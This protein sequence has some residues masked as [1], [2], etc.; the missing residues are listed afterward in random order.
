MK[1]VELKNINKYYGNDLILEDISFSIYSG[2]VVGFLGPNGAGKSTTMRILCG[3]L[4]PDSGEYLFQKEDVLLNPDMIKNKIGYLPEDPP[5][6]G[7]LRVKENLN[8]FYDL[9]ESSGNKRKD[10]N[11][12][13]DVCGL[14][15][16]LNKLT[17]TLSKGY[18][19]RLGLAI[20][21]LGN[22]ELI[23]LD[24]PTVGLDPI[25][26]KETRNLIKNLSL[27][28]TIILSSHI[29][30]EVAEICNRVLIIN[31]GKIL[32]E[33][34][35]ETL[36]KITGKDYYIFKISGSKDTFLKRLTELKIINEFNVIEESSSDFTLRISS[37]E[38]ADVRKEL[39]KVINE[40]DEWNLV[41]MAKAELSLEDVFMDILERKEP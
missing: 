33:E 8:F 31:K 27:K 6:Y 4:Y 9:K 1:L 21:L 26:I 17:N 41:E 18:R 22:P 2:D 40:S 12:I 23:I 24:E 19:Q 35:T 25:Q 36:K 15:E 3:L 32:T 7:Y 13:I 10:L 28:T 16:V 14:G 5:V 11:K 34:T 30:S 39:M 38:G 37:L 20:A 29:L